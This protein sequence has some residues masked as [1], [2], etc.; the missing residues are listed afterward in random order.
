MTILSG[1]TKP[2]STDQ[3][4]HLTLSG[5]GVKRVLASGYD[6][7][8]LHDILVDTAGAIQVSGS[9]FGSTDNLTI[10]ETVAAPL[11]TFVITNGV[12]TKTIVINSSTLITTITWS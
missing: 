4:E 10:T 12:K 11:D 2:S 9:G 7:T 8:N 6:G 1:A 3:D 5:V